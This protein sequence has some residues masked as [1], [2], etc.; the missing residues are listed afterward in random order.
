MEVR[1][2]QTALP[3][4]LL[5]TAAAAVVAAKVALRGLVEPMPAMDRIAARPLLLQARLIVAA[6]VVV[7]EQRQQRE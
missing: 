3:V 6:E 2:P 7:E 5:L 4:L 1:A